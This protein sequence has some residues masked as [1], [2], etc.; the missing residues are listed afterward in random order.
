[1]IQSD[2]VASASRETLVDCKW[3]HELCEGVAQLFVAAVS[4]TF[5]TSTHPLRY[6]WLDY[7]PQKK[8]DHPWKSL[9]SSIK[10]GLGSKSILQTRER[11]LFKPPN[12]LRHLF[13]HMLHCGIPIIPD[14]FE[15][16]YLAPEYAARHKDRLTDLGVPNIN[17]NL[18]VDR[19]QADLAQTSSKVRS[20]PADDP[21]HEA[22]AGLFL[23]AFA[24]KSLET[25]QRRIKRL[26][27][28]PLA[29]PNQW[30]GAPG[31]NSGGSDKIYFPFTDDTP[32]PH[33]LPLRLLD[34]TA[35]KKSTRKKFYRALGVKKCPKATVFAEIKQAHCKEEPPLDPTDQLRYLFHQCCDPS[36]VKTWIWIPLTNGTMVKSV[37]YKLYFP[38]DGKYDT[39]E[40]LKKRAK[41]R[42][43]SSSLV[44][45]EPADVR[46]ESESWEAW[47]A[48][49]TGARYHPPLTATGLTSESGYTLSPSLR[50][51][52]RYEPRK[53]L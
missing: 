35:S 27:I 14:L 36:D 48:R 17:W 3:N 23:S 9:L 49:I 50:S 7:L 34:E 51:V 8:M 21:W 45:A 12:Q 37:R 28:I 42:F 33:S 52:L 53:F 16:I 20:T 25:V 26:A 39:Y 24:S 31:I 10:T 30:T 5:A 47:L 41:F 19:L 38:S 4:E 46:V 32:I 2:F 44:D 6:S 1:L 22:F 40:L 18:V 13:P 29:K 11:R 43:L 15:E